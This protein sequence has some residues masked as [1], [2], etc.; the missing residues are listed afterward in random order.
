MNSIIVKGGYGG[1]LEVRRSQTIEVVN[2][3][4]GQVCDFFAFN[5]DNVREHL[6]PGH[7]RSVL[8]K[9]NL[10]VG[11][12]LCSVLRNPMLELL[13]DTT[14][15][16]DFCVPQCDPQR[17]V[18]DFGVSGHRNCRD[19][20]AEAM[21]DYDIPYEYL[22]EPFNFFQSSPIDSDGSLRQQGSPAR[23]GDKVALRAL[24]DV[25]VAVSACPQDLAPTN[26]YELTDL[27]LIVR[28]PQP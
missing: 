19:N 13:E 3:Q 12:R 26:N 11:D 1:R 20:L 17:Y 4:G 10:D 21:T 15:V 23:A 6:S 8:R 22:P 14:G 25:I 24:M 5:A 27:E 28:D 9:V 2:V 7:T 18:Q 16:N